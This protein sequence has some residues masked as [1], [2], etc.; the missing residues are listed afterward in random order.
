[1]TGRHLQKPEPYGPHGIRL[2]DQRPAHRR[3]NP[4]EDLGARGEHA[5]HRN[6]RRKNCSFHKYQLSATS[7]QLSAISYQHL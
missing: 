3:E 4:I 2:Q 1:M 7:H 6:D 5:G